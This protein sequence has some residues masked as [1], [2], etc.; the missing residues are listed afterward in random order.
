MIFSQ[1]VDVLKWY[2]AELYN[3]GEALSIAKE[4]YATMVGEGINTWASFL[5]QPEIGLTVREA[6]S[7]IQ[8]YEWVG[9]GDVPLADLNLTTAK[10]CALKGIPMEGMEEDMKVLSL[11][12]FKD[13]HYD[14]VSKEDNA[15]RT[16]TYMVMKR[17]NE[18]G[19]LTK[20]Y[21]EGVE[22]LEETIKTKLD[23]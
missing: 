16:Y 20:V 18:T 13:R 9:D 4:S 23:G 10:F 15:P 14:V 3:V 8:L 2:K 5:E 6:N 11:K 21:G 17:C 22:E 19:N 7:L 1:L 12:D